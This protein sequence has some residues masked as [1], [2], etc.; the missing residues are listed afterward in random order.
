MSP[1]K[2]SSESFGLSKEQVEIAIKYY[3]DFISDESVR[4]PN[5]KEF[6]FFL[7]FFYKKN[8]VLT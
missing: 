8:K 5:K 3:D 6:T 1:E 2:S 4:R 7:L